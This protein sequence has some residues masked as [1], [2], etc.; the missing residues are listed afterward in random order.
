MTG[1]PPDRRHYE[2]Q[3]PEEIENEFDGWTV[4]RGTSMLWFAQLDGRVLVRGE[5][6]QDLRDAII[7]WIRRQAYADERGARG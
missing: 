2:P 5:D 1:S 3:S 4:V 7:V 6:L